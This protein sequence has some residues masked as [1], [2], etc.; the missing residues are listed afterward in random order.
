[1]HA[2]LF[3]S[4]FPCLLLLLTFTQCSYGLGEF[5]KQSNLFFNFTC[6]FELKDLASDEMSI[7]VCSSRGVTA[8]CN[9]TSSSKY[10]VMVNKALYGLKN[11]SVNDC[12]HRFVS[13]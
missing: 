11:A 12:E 2:I 3:L 8:T 4:M 13:T 10:T 5:Y 1:M 9:S 7:N 6:W